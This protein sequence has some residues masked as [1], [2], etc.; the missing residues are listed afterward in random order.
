MVKKIAVI[1]VNSLIVLSNV[2]KNGYQISVFDS[3]K[4]NLRVLQ[5]LVTT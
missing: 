4:Y 2:R 1:W 5:N 3:I